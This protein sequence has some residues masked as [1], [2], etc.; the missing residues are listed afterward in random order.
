MN[1]ITEYILEE[2]KATSITRVSRQTKIKK[3]TGQL[4]SVTARKRSDPLYKKMVRYRELYYKYR[5][6]I[7]QKYS[8]RVRSQARR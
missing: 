6:M 5:A 8:P 4:A 1:P 3:A 2:A 7:H